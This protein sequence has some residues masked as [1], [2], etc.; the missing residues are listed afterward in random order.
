MY[1]TVKIYYGLQNDKYMD[2]IGNAGGWDLDRLNEGDWEIDQLGNS[3]LTSFLQ[4]TT[5]VL[6]VAWHASETDLLVGSLLGF[7]S[8]AALRDWLDG[9]ADAVGELLDEGLLDEF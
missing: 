5:S 4:E 6:A 2:L 8:T 3:L 9:E 1:S 7:E